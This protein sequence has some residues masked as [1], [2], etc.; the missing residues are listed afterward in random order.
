MSTWPRRRAHRERARDHDLAVLLDGVADL[1]DRVVEL[2]LGDVERT[3]EQVGLQVGVRLHRLAP[4]LAEAPR[5]L[6][7]HEEDETGDRG[8]GAELRDQDGEPFRPA[9]ADQEVHERHEQRRDQHG[10]QQRDDDEVELDDEEQHESHDCRDHQDPPRPG[11]RDLHSRWDRTGQGASVG[12]GSALQRHAAAR[13]AIRHSALR[14]PR[15]ARAPWAEVYGG[16]AESLMSAAI[17]MVG[18][19]SRCRRR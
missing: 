12:C 8:E 1:G 11:T 7:H 3:V 10:D 6:G 5:D 15:R 4:E 19:V 14:R 9:M 16:L 2:R 13:R 18:P 17:V